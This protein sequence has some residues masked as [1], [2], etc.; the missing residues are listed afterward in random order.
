M[1][2]AAFDLTTRRGVHVNPHHTLTGRPGA[3]MGELALALG[4]LEQAL[5][6]LGYP[7]GSPQY[8]QAADWFWSNEH[9]H[10]FSCSH[11]CELFGWDLQSVRQRLGA[12]HDTKRDR[13]EYLRA[14]GMAR[15]ETRRG[16][17]G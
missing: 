4:V 17:R 12:V 14:A 10:V 3:P 2:A 1:T 5:A 8:R 6:D 15:W 7:P 16:R 11:I 13:H 9:Q